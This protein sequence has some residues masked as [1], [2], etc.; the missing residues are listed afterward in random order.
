MEKG[1]TEKKYCGNCESE[2]VAMVRESGVLLC[3]TCK[4]AYQWGQAS[5]NLTIVEVE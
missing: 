3:H 1:E 4:T 2:A 5:P